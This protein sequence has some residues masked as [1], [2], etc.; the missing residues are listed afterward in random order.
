LER[1]AYGKSLN[2]WD[3]VSPTNR[4]QARKKA[5]KK[6]GGREVI[7][8]SIKFWGGWGGELRGKK[9]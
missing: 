2:E 6:T 5:Q 4:R 8:G 1:K 7:K 3:F 9:R